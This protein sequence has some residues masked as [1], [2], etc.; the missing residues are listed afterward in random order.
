MTDDDLVLD[1]TSAF[2]GSE[3]VVTEK[4]DGENCTLYCDFMH[5][6]SIQSRDHPSRHW[7]KA[8]H[9]SICRSIPVG[10]RLCGENLF[11]THAL[12]YENLEGYFYLFS[13]WNE[14]NECLSWDETVA[15]ARTLEVPTPKVLYRGLWNEQKMRNLPIDTTVSEGYVVRTAQ[16]FAYS[17]FANHVAKWVRK[18]HV[19]DSDTHWMMRQ[20]IPNKLAWQKET[21]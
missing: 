6:R 14:N 5:A 1:T 7:L 3:V 15:W 12:R 17:E 2:I 19:G 16:G 20:V 8:F 18:E 10:W 9:A 21:P 13:V 4:L 11:A